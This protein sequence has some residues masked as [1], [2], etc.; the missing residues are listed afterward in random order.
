MSCPQAELCIALLLPRAARLPGPSQQE[1]DTKPQPNGRK[2]RGVV[3]FYRCRLSVGSS[4]LRKNFFTER[5]VRHWQGLPRR[6]WSPQPW[7]CPRNDCM[8]HSVFWAGWQGGDR[9]QL[10]LDDPGGVFHPKWLGG[11]CSWQSHVVAGHF[12]SVTTLVH[13]LSCRKCHL[14]RYCVCVCVCDL[15]TQT[16]SL[17]VFSHI[18]GGKWKTFH[19]WEPTELMKQTGT[20][21]GRTGVSW[22]HCRSTFSPSSACVRQN[23]SS[24]DESISLRAGLQG[25]L[26]GACSSK[27]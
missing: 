5:V 25:C 19:V 8:W 21:R 16:L 7:R 6:W 22:S 13:M 23:Q 9:A 14:C 15:K 24:R 11:F 1:E 17:Q 10:G 12:G 4:I 26:T 20:F 27:T 2:E 3:L 18:A